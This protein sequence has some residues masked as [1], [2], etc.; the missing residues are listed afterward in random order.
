MQR[1]GDGVRLF[2]HNQDQSRPFRPLIACVRRITNDTAA[3]QRV[4]R[5][6]SLSGQNQR[7]TESYR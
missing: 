4:Q 7:I 6:V 3:S 2:S 1:G 5:I